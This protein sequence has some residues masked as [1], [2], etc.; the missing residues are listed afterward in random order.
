MRKQVELD[1]HVSHPLLCE[2][3]GMM[4]SFSEPYFHLVHYMDLSLILPL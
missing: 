1:L 4:N 3:L 2:T